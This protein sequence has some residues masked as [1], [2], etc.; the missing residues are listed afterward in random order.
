MVNFT[1][2]LWV[3]V[4]KNRFLIG[5]LLVV[6]LSG[7]F[8]FAQQA[9][10]DQNALEGTE[11]K[12]L[13]WFDET[14]KESKECGYKEF[15]GA[16]MYQGLQ[17]FE[18]EEEC[19]KALEESHQNSEETETAEC[20]KE[21]ERVNRNPLM[22]STDRECCE[23]LMEVRESKSYSVCVNCGDGTCDEFENEK[24]CPQ[25]CEGE[26]KCCPP[27]CRFTGTRSEGWYDSCTGER[28]KWANCEGCKAVCLGKG[29]RSEGW[30]S[31]CKGQEASMGT[32]RLIKWGCGGCEANYTAE[33]V[34]VEEEEEGEIPVENVVVSSG[35]EGGGQAYSVGTCSG[36]QPEECTEEYAP[37]CATIEHFNPD[38]TY[39]KYKKTF[40]NA[41]KA[42]AASTRTNTV[43]QYVKRK[44]EQD[45]DVECPQIERPAPGF[46]PSGKIKPVY[47]EI[48]GKKCIVKYEC[49]PTS[50][51]PVEQMPVFMYNT[52]NSSARTSTS[53]KLYKNGTMYEIKKYRDHTEKL[54]GE[55]SESRVSEFLKT[56]GELGFFK[57]K[58]LMDCRKRGGMIECPV[59]ATNHKIYARLE[60]KENKLAWYNGLTEK[61]EAIVYALKKVE[62]FEDEMESQPDHS[63]KYVSL[64]KAFDLYIGGKAKVRETGFKIKLERIENKV[65]VFSVSP[66]YLGHVEEAEEKEVKGELQGKEEPT[67]SGTVPGSTGTMPPAHKWIEIE[68]GGKETVFGHD[69][70]LNSVLTPRCEEQKTETGKTVTRCIGAK[71]YANLTITKHHDPDTQI[72]AYL[73]KEFAMKEKDYAKIL[74]S[75]GRVVMGMSL[76][77]VYIPGCELKCKINP[78]TGE[79]QCEDV[80]C[81]RRAVAK[82]LVNPSPGG[83]EIARMEPVAI[84]E[85]ESKRIG[86]YKIYFA[87]LVNREKAV[88][89]VKKVEDDFEYKEVEL[90]ELFKLNVRETALIVEKDIFVTLVNI[91]GGPEPKPMEG[92][93]EKTPPE[94]YNPRQYAVVS[95]WK[96]G[97]GV[98]QTPVAE[99]ARE[100]IETIKKNI[101]RT[102][103]K[104]KEVQ[105]TR[106]GTAMPDIMP[107]RKT[108]R[109]RIGQTLDIYDIKLTLRSLKEKAGEFIAEADDF[110]DTINVHVGEP[111]E[112]EEDMSAR[113]LEANMRIDLLNLLSQEICAESMPP[114]CREIKQ[115]KIGVRKLFKREKIGKTVSKSVISKQ[116]KEKLVEEAAEEGQAVTSQQ[117][118][119]IEMP[120]TPFKVFTL[121]EGESAEVGEFEIKVLAIWA[122]RAE[123]IVKEKSTGIQFKLVIAK[124]WNLFSIPGE[125]RALE[126]SECKSSDFKLFEYLPK[127]KRFRKVKKPEE[128]KAY[129][130]YNPGKK[131][132]VNAELE[133]AVS[134]LELEDLIKGWNFL[135]VLKGMFEKKISEMGDCELKGAFFFDSEN[136]KW[137]KAMD[138]VL[139]KEHLGTG[140]AVYANKK[141][142]IVGPGG[143]PEIPDLPE[144]PEVE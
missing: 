143:P 17:T 128:G 1:K 140:I 117:I 132:I 138:T 123:F 101:E 96:K 85:G 57:L 102:G 114:Q 115:V 131:C 20:A 62:E 83:A 134:M 33:A 30:Y 50:I 110:S 8:V 72:T 100:R 69:V 106:A 112:L 52:E 125:I 6:L 99:Q 109:L 25:D 26:K 139:G 22:G 130:L 86:R 105:Q 15:C 18:T 88:F 82:L 91:T 61:P 12:K 87:D 93:K 121:G 21:G 94:I 63:E 84:R 81:D 58:E 32:D 95:V 89:V 97:W 42:C 37:V 44:C 98:A 55:I 108:Y 38:G 79:S 92:A 4:L 34:E 39:K 19:K 13:Y 107:Y 7:V 120:P 3:I 29:T 47:G 49:K 70:T 133:K 59:G 60:N 10:Q 71:P 127:E 144:L 53:F 135:P 67:V 41:C 111:F 122:E 64:G 54:K 80:E 48:Q 76:T 113:V 56:L 116:A 35:E 14:T 46:C 129:W 124:G 90:D 104:V 74:N 43:I 28:I 68:V 75:T 40:S 118:E 103:R 31:V 78:E 66:G 9:S 16:Y 23:G 142:S 24:N 126:H 136:N 36:E 2:K 73:G 119:P 65:A 27:K 45:T 11:C 5:I 77:S 137:V 141:C 51:K